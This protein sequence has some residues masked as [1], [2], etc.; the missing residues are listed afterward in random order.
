MPLHRPRRNRKS[1]AIRDLCRETT[2]SAADLVYPLFLHADGVETPLESLPG[3]TRWS[4][5]G[6]VGEAR[7]AWDLGI[8]AVVPVPQDRGRAQDLRRRRGA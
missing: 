3:Q 1:A 2:L 7:R 5:D 8:R 4:L 6:L